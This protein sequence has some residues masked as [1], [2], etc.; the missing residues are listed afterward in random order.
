[1]SSLYEQ[2]SSPAALAA[3]WQRVKVKGRAGGVDQ[4]NVAEATRTEGTW[5]PLLAEQLASRT[6]RPLPYLSMDIP[7]SNGERRGI[8]LP[9]IVDK[10][11]QTAV[12]DILQPM[13]EPRLSPA[14][15]AYQPDKGAARCIRRILHAVR[16]EHRAWL[17]ACDIDNFFDSIDRSVLLE[18]LA[19]VVG[20]AD[21]ERLI[22]MWIEMGK[23]DRD[24][25]WHDSGRGIPQGS[26]ISG[27]LAN[28]Y[29]TDVDQRLA[30]SASGYVRYADNLLFMTASENEAQEM[31]SRT[32]A[33][34]AD[35]LGLAL[36]DDVASGPAD[37]GVDF[38]G[39]IVGTAGVHLSPAKLQELLARFD[40]VAASV[41]T[42]ITLG[43]L[44]DEM[45]GIAAYYGELL[46]QL[47]LESLDG[48]V[49][50]NLVKGLQ[51]HGYHGGFSSRK[52]LLL[53][54]RN[55]SYLSARYIM[56]GTRV[57]EQLLG[58]A[59]SPPACVCREPAKPPVPPHEPV[60]SPS[61][62]EPVAERSEPLPA[63]QVVAQRKKEYEKRA[64]G[65][66]ELLVSAFGAYVGV[67]QQQVYIMLD[68]KVVASEGIG[69]LKH[70][71]IASPAISI[72][73]NLLY[74]CA[75]EGISVDFVDKQG[76]PFA[77]LQTDDD[78][79][80]DLQLAQLAAI[81]DGRGGVIA[82]AIVSGKATNQ[83]NLLKY[84]LKS[85]RDP[86]QRSAILHIISLIET[87]QREEAALAR[88]D[89]DLDTLR[90]KLFAVEGRCAALYWDAI[91]LVLSNVIEV[92]SRE[93]QGAGDLFNSLLN[94]GYGIL[95]ARVWQ[96]VS[97][98][99]LNPHISYLHS[100]QPGKPTLVFDLVEEFRQDVVDRCVIA[101]LDRRTSLGQT[102]GKLTEETRKKLATK[103]L[104]RLETPVPYHG[105]P[106][107]LSD[108][109]ASQAR[110][111]RYVLLGASPAYHTYRLKW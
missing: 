48:R 97:A 18:K 43:S 57:A 63:Q 53:A 78:P 3:A 96:A 5:L 94:Y 101:M 71:V 2:C 77:R 106:T 75:Q 1:V 24:Q 56:G 60:S 64:R 68:R 93:G 21:V 91:R 22:A 44:H 110:L 11:C 76:R 111:F 65:G 95:Y 89:E 103:V 54:L 27:L 8:S 50:E 29:L 39:V 55:I 61:V 79:S 104:S 25:Q 88:F 42:P 87:V 10:V 32:R 36:N 69:L 38:L 41:V 62:D 73:S 16:N 6:Y 82:R 86:G 19:L 34:L 99:R 40:S 7:K 15:Y 102:N 23:V 52:D 13:L 14:S 58:R 66:S 49:F 90:G 47:V 92:P 31:L 105:A 80:A 45:R 20:D 81:S 9:A 100:D 4:V 107:L 28:L 98:Q 51:N 12:L 46:D 70:V 30:P 108:V 17:M 35:S 33:M 109:V 37:C 72:S 67:R 83:V 74:S 84:L 26:V 59:F 85:H